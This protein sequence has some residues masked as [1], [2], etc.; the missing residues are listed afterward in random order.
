MLALFQP[1]ARVM[2]R[3]KYPQK[4]LLIS[5]LFLLPLIVVITQFLSKINEDI[6]FAEKERL[7]L[8][9]NAP[10]IEFLQYIQ[11]HASLKMAIL[12]GDSSL[13][14][15]ALG[16]AQQAADEAV[17]AVNEVDARYGDMLDTRSTWASIKSMWMSVKNAS[18]GM[19][20]ATSASTYTELLN[21]ILKLVVISGNSSNLILDPD[22]DSYYLMDTVIN[23]LPPLTEYLSQIRSYSTASFVSKA[24][25]QE[26]IT[27]LTI[28]SGLVNNNVDYNVQGFGYSF[29]AN[30]ELRAVLQEDVAAY[31]RTITAL[32]SQMNREMNS[33]GATSG[34][35]TPQAV[36]DAATVT[37]DEVYRFYPEV[38]SSLDNLIV[39]R[40]GRFEARRS[41]VSVVALV[42]IA[43]AIYLAIGFYVAV[44]Q[45]IAGL[46]EATQRM[47]K[48]DM[49]YRFT[50]ASRDE[51]AQVA[52][53]FNNIASEL[54]VARD[55][56]LESNRAKSAFLANMSHELRTPLNAIIGYSELIE[57]EMVDEGNNEFIPDLKKIQTAA[58][59]LLSLINDILDLSKIEAGKME[60]FMETVNIPD[61]I[62]EV[63]MTILPLIE[64]NGNRLEV[65]CPDWVGLMQTDLT[66]TRQIL[67]NL[68]SNASK[69]TLKGLVKLDLDRRVEAG[70]EVI[71]FTIT[72]SGIGMTSEQL[73]KLFKDFSQADSSTTRK[74]GG[75]GLGLSISRRFAQML[76]GDIT[77]TSQI[78]IGSSFTLKLPVNREQIVQP[79][80]E[81]ISTVTRK[82][83]TQ[84][85]AAFAGT[86]LVIDDDPTARELVNRFMLKEGYNVYTAE[87]GETGLKMAR[88]L[89]PDV[90]TLD[91]MMPRMD[92]WSVLNALKSDAQ[93]ASIPVIMLTMV[94][95]QNLGYALGAADYVTK[96]IDRERLIKILKRYECNVPGC[97]VL[98]VDDEPQIREIIQRTMEKEGWNVLQAGDGLEALQVVQQ[99]PP[100]LIL[101]DLMMPHMDGF[102]FLQ[103]LR[104]LPTGT[105]IPVIVI[106]AMDLS[107]GDHQRLNGSVEQVLQ[108][109]AYSQEQLLNEVRSLVKSMALNRR[110]TQE[111]RTTS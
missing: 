87:D 39:A 28:L 82:R 22:I 57:E 49:N 79:E 38:S 68:L 24:V 45:T 71:A 21:N 96:P 13:N 92:G 99:K 75:T 16:E 31:Q 93:L 41:V 11:R 19:N 26:D 23:K 53:S 89:R 104:K 88:E 37:I 2:S 69:F 64:K 10:V 44:K 35:M 15:T 85:V 46:D 98:V 56:A 51:L 29:A 25:T 70:E 18:P 65:N 90:I 67:F 42:A 72:D 20:P 48:G 95:D 103:E 8:I 4:F 63:T 12:K 97:D 9:Y 74:F 62:K 52:V 110:S 91:V 27:R 73:I 66:K 30:P 100:Q 17:Q 59:H 36:Y 83:K 47:V 105:D 101:L 40:V 84:P 32:L 80:V 34:S 1:A 76:G 108:K 58:A 102:G 14:T 33:V 60:L 111:M 50:S 77:V 43:A 7:G 61:M 109:G 78:S 55:Q 107:S 6:D 94:S 5:I 86:L 3:L 54:M 81:P 106:T